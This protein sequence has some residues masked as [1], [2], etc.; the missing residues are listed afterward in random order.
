MNTR[1]FSALAI[2][3]LCFAC[4]TTSTTSPES[5]SPTLPPQGNQDGMRPA[6]SMPRDGRAPQGNLDGAAASPPAQG[7]YDQPRPAQGNHDGMKDHH[8]MKDSRSSLV[9]QSDAADSAASPAD[10]DTEVAIDVY[11]VK[12]CS[13]G[14]AKVYFPFDSAKLKGGDQRL[15][16]LAD[17]VTT[18]ALKGKTLMLTGHADPRGSKQYNKE[19]G[20]SRAETVADALASAGVS[21][22]RL[23]L[24]SK[25][26]KQASNDSS[27]WPTDRRVEIEL[28]SK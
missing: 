28:E 18:G 26:E 10:D 27:D 2:V 20:K 17:C 1:S 4:A 11:L 7:S 15:R 9:A 16:P 14:T 19:L 13:L 24:N 3:P 5:P 6:T 12:T 22:D 21:R 25:G 8:E 23:K